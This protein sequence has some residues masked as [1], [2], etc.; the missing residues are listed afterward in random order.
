MGKFENSFICVIR[1]LPR[2]KSI[3]DILKAKNV[4]LNFIC[5]LNIIVTIIFR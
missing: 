5:I 4:D 2:K 1:F 3:K